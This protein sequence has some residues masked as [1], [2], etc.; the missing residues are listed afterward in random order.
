M[1]QNMLLLLLLFM[2][3]AAVNGQSDTGQSDTVTIV[4]FTPYSDLRPCAARSCIEWNDDLIV[5]EYYLAAAIG[6]NVNPA[7]ENNCFCRTD[8]I[9]SGAIWLSSCVSRSCSDTNDA[10]SATSIYRAYCSQAGYVP[11]SAP[12]ET[13]L[14]TI[15]TAT[16]VNTATGATL[17]GATGG[18]PTSEPTSTSGNTDSSNGGGSSSGGLSP[19]SDTAIA[20]ASLVVATLTLWVGWRTYIW[21][22]RH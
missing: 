6:C 19:G 18:V 2:F 15:A 9:N 1:V 12:A 22:K 16:N 8:L 4:D 21:M 13:T 7:P 5:F 10:T 3:Y 20:V 14:A 11:A 17:P